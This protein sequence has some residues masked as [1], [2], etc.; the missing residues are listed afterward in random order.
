MNDSVRTDQYV[1]VDRGCPVRT[2]VHAVDD[3]VEIIFG[4]HRFG[5]STLRLVIDDPDM[6]L[7][8]T[9]TL[10]DTRA[11]FLDHLRSR[12]ARTDPDLLRGHDIARSHGWLNGNG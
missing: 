5:G 4:E 6:L 2:D 11:R 3:F 9:E 7:R 1:Y 10:A 12:Q 8:L